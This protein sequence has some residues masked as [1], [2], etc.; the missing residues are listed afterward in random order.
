MPELWGVT[1]TQKQVCGRSIAEKGFRLKVE[2]MKA[3]FIRG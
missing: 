3:E 2:M 1:L